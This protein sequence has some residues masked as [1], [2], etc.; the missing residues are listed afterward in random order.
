MPRP[1]ATA[2]CL[3]ALA[4]VGCSSS[5]PSPSLESVLPATLDARRGGPLTVTGRDFVP[6]TQVDFE[7]PASSVTNATFTVTLEGGAGTITLTE[8]ARRDTEHLDARVPPGQEAGL[9]ALVVVDP[10]GHSARLRDAVT[11]YGPC[12]SAACPDGGGEADGGA[13]GGGLPDAGPGDGGSGDGGAG[14]GGV[15]DGGSDGGLDGGPTPCT[16]LTFQD[17]DGDGVGDGAT[18]AMLCG[19]GRVTVSGDCNDADALAYPGAPE[20]CNRLDDNCNGQVDEAPAC[21][22]LNPTWKLVANTGTQ[23]WNQAW[24]WARGSVWI[25]GSNALRV[26]RGTGA[27]IDVLGGCATPQNDVWADPATGDAMTAG[28]QGSGARLAG[29][30]LVAADCGAARSASTRV[31]GLTGF[32]RAGDVDFYGVMRT[33][34]L[35]TWTQTGALTN[36]YGSGLANTFKVENL[37]GAVPQALFAVGDDEAVTP[38][39][40]K[41]W[42]ID[43]PTHAW[44]DLHAEAVAGLPSGRLRAV[45]AL[46]AGLAY[47]VGDAGTALEWRDGAWRLLPK[48][49][50]ANLVAVRAFGLGRVYVADD[51]G[52]VHLWNGKAW[53]PLL[54]NGRGAAWGDLTG[55]FEDDLWAVGAQGLVAHWPE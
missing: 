15:Q 45:W 47:L 55:A 49:T 12:G 5:G 11:L 20:V 37:H 32:P 46:S 25:S 48:P 19:P 39:R 1:L 41:A 31:H 3:F 51:V 18:G 40:M 50:A 27:F 35:V 34:A 22:V 28:L 29:H 26:R 17:G 16:T 36:E 2:A 38:A 33:P 30:L 53:L 14:D 44:A 21:P 13:D 24:A 43:G 54:D 52:F 8:V 9:Y 42:R 23:A 4:L 6:L 10:R 7:D